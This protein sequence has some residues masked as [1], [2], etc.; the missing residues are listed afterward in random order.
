MK[1]LFVVLAMVCFLCMGSMAYAVDTNGLSETQKAEIAMQI[2]KMK[3]EKASPQPSTPAKVNEW[4]Q[5][6]QNV[7]YALIGA[8]DKVGI[9]VEKFSETKVGKVTMAI[10]IWKMMGSAIIHVV[11]GISLWIITTTI[12][13]YFYRRNV[14]ISSVTYTPVPDRF[15][16]KKVV[17]YRNMD[18]GVGFVYALIWG[19]TTGI[20]LL[21]TFNW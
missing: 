4:V 9:A 12:L 15:W 20:A 17:E 7:G 3:E 14:S 5:V 2:A 16:R 10:V 19:A 13:F 6:G 1:K 18:D 21:V 8:A 11:V